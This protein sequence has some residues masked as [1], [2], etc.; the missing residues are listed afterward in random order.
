VDFRGLAPTAEVR[1]K[2]KRIA[3][4]RV[5]CNPQTCLRLAYWSSGDGEGEAELDPRSSPAAGPPLVLVVPV[6]PLELFFDDFLV[7][8]FVEVPVLEVPV[9]DFVPAPVWALLPV[10]VVDVSF[11]FV[12]AVTNANPATAL[13]LRRRDFFIGVVVDVRG[14]LLCSV[15]LHRRSA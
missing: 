1:D 14:Q 8:F 6:V 4:A 3:A 2:K 10:V 5:G 12:H 13:R 9:P 11:V 15:N 7:D